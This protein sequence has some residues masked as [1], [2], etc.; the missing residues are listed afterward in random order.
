MLR[1]KRMF[2]FLSFR[3]SFKPMLTFTLSKFLLGGVLLASLLAFVPNNVSA[4]SYGVDRPEANRIYYY[5]GCNTVRAENGMVAVGARGN[6]LYSDSQSNG[7]G[8]YQ[9]SG[10]LNHYADSDTPSYSGNITFNLD[11]SIN[12]IGGS[13]TN[14]F[15]T[16][17]SDYDSYLGYNFRNSVNGFSFTFDSS[18]HQMYSIPDTQDEKF[19]KY[20]IFT[21]WK[22]GDSVIPSHLIPSLVNPNPIHTNNQS[23][24]ESEL[25]TFINDI[26]STSVY[27]YDPKGY[28]SS[29]FYN[30]LVQDFGIVNN[31]WSEYRFFGFFLPQYNFAYNLR[32]LSFSVRTDL[33]QNTLVGKLE[34][35]KYYVG[36][37]A[38][39][40][41][42]PKVNYMY[43]SPSYYKASNTYQGLRLFDSI[44]DFRSYGIYCTDQDCIDSN[45]SL[46]SK[47]Q[48]EHNNSVGSFE[49]LQTSNPAAGWFNIFNFG[50]IFPW[51]TWFDGFTNNSCVD[52]PNIASWLHTNQSHYCT[53]WPANIRQSL[54]PIFNSISLMVIFG[55][56]VSWLKGRSSNAFHDNDTSRLGDRF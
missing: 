32:D 27:G 3:K 33:V 25:E 41:N 53:F 6:I 11:G 18:D 4:Y 10:G 45:A 37:G 17:I 50:L 56:V 1:V 23:F 44:S 30:Q 51:S 34:F 20:Q 15:S 14:V 52:V 54:T 36:I 47:Y 49:N 48:T 16:S 55:F 38:S 43:L 24:T 2:T 35:H 42:L 13:F 46:V 22:E 40:A 8:Y 26:Y 9:N 7:C 19:G 39:S 21:I 28:V 5:L 12:N 29:D 31:D